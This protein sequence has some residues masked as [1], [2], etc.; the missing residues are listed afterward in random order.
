MR[1]AA[2]FSPG[3]ADFFCAAAAL[4]LASCAAATPQPADPGL[5]PVHALVSEAIEARQYLGAVM[6]LSRDG[7][8]VDWRAW[9]H[10]DLA[11][12]APHHPDDIFALYSLTKPIA[13]AAVLILADER[14]LGLDDRLGR[15][16]PEFG[17]RA[18]TLRHLLTHTSGLAPPTAEMERA[19]DLRAYA[20]LA[21]AVPP[22]HPPGTRFQYLP[23]NTELASRVVEVASGR[24]FDQFLQKSIF[25]PLGMRDTGF[26]VPPAQRHRLATL[27][28]T[29][30]AGRLIQHPAIDARFRGDR[31]RRYN[32]G[33]AGLYST[34]GDYVRFCH[35]LAAG[36]ELDGRRILSLAS[37]EAMFTNQLTMLDPPVSQYG[38]GFGLGGFVNLDDPKRARPGSAG[39]FGW[40]GASSTYFTIDPSRRLVAILFLQHVPQGLPND[41]GKLS[42]RFYNLVYQWLARPQRPE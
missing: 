24:P 36:G 41:P 32:S 7:R 15:H 37:V 21:A 18:I 25:E 20:T 30:A 23:V 38:E 17:S 3:T 40:S 11:R 28:S 34:V 19:P 8:V 5:A 42:F 4:A 26:E 12:T 16:L 35:M 31:V 2:V 9:G 22:S 13:T 10:R 39:G 27:T 6:L 29:D 33:A 14:R 1:P